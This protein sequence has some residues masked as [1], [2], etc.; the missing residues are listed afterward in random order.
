MRERNFDSKRSRHGHPNFRHTSRNL[1]A[2][3]LAEISLQHVE[4]LHIPHLSDKHIIVKYFRYVDDILI[5][6]DT[7]HSD[8]QSILKDFNTIHPKLT[9][10]A[11]CEVDNQINFLDITINRTHTNWK[12]AIH[13]KPTFTDTVIPYTSNHPTQH[14]HAARQFLFNRLNTYNLQEDDY[15]TEI[16]TIQNIL[17]NNAFPTEMHK[18]PPTTRMPP[19]T[20]KEQ[21]TA[22]HTHTKLQTQNWATFTYIGKQT[23]F[24]TNLFKK[25]DIKIAFR[26]DNIQNLLTR[27]QQNTDPYSRSGVYKLT[28]PNCGKAYVGQTGRSFTTRSRE[29]KEAF[30]TASRP[31]NFAKHLTDHAHSF[32]PIQNVM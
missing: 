13:R 25:A 28:C 10:T 20:S 8:I 4:K 29:H 26:T 16:N 24:I 30:K 14:K 5:I 23:T 12:I 17:H 3:I 6:H 9:F 22:V 15:N 21:T 27:K 19:D 18:N 11:E 32:G 31:S 7:N 2:T 1:F